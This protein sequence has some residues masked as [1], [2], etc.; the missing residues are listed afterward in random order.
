M[1]IKQIV[2]KDYSNRAIALLKTNKRIILNLATGVGKSKIAID[3]INSYNYDNIK[4]LFI[5]AERAHKKNW[6]EEFDKWKLITDNYR[7]ECYNSL[8]KC[9]EDNYDIVIFDEAHHLCT[10]LRFMYHDNVKAKKF[11]YLSATS[12]FE[13][14]EH[15]N[16]IDYKM[17]PVIYCS[18]KRA[19][20][21]KVLPTP[22]VEV[23]MLSLNNT[24]PSEYYIEYIG[25][26]E[27]SFNPKTMVMYECNY[28][29][30][31]EYFRTSFL[32]RERKYAVKVYCTQQEKYNYYNRIIE[33]YKNTYLATR[34]EWAKIKWLRAG[35][36]RKRF[37]G[38]IKT[39]YAKNLIKTLHNKRFICFCTSIDQANKIGNKNNII[40]SKVKNPL[41]VIESFNNK[42]INSLVAVGM[43]QE[44][45]NLKDIEC[46][47]IVQLD[48]KEGPFIQKFGRTLRSEHPVQ[49]IIC[50]KGTQDN[51]YLE[52]VIKNLDPNHVKYI[53]V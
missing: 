16:A 19:I 18:L 3:C 33:E 2:S 4:V 5:V 24:I 17:P 43:L 51:V 29:R 14:L 38:T 20:E 1:N 32:I 44:G 39:N 21:Q 6:K 42:D 35:S 52:R 41:D 45:Q 13:L 34:E 23:H 46:G 10:P 37:L 25:C 22:K 15:L 31:M 47:I 30:R 36:E 49:Y 11:I 48:G 40:H 9:L 8:H 28:S 53:E 27:K 12:K 7:I 26:T 50:I